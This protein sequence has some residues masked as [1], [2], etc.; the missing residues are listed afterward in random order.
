MAARAALLGYVLLASAGGCQCRSRATGKAAR[1]ADPGATASAP[2]SAA[3]GATGLAPDAQQSTGERIVLGNVAVH[4]V[5][6]EVPREIY[7]RHLAQRLG[8]QLTESGL[9]AARATDVPAGLR[10][11]TASL[12]LRIRYDVL[13]Q[14]G[15]GGPTVVAAVESRIIWDSAARDIAPADN[16]IAERPLHESGELDMLVVA[17]IAATVEQAGRG[18]LAKERLRTAGDEALTAV[19]GDPEATVDMV[20][21]VLELAGQR[22]SAGLYEAVAGRLAAE[23]PVVR[24]RAVD[25]L[26]MLGDRRA[27]DRLAREARF[28]DHAFLRTVIEAVADLGGD[29]ARE[30][31]AFLASGHPEQDIRA[32]AAAGLERLSGGRAR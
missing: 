4:T 22:R 5:D 30:Y 21:W 26:V 15:R 27:V 19:L 13:D 1:Q 7:P 3:A 14:G 6:P 20:T 18:L 9:F 24:D 11:R 32:R 25:A 23:D 12:E 2:A 16:V 10:A 17:H 29:D 8:R 28:D 31:L